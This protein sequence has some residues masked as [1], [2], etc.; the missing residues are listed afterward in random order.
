MTDDPSARRS[1]DGQRDQVNRRSVLKGATALAA[2]AVPARARITAAQEPAA[3]PPAWP[4]V[5]PASSYPAPDYTYPD[6]VIGVSYEDSTPDFPQPPGAPKGAPNILLVLLDDV[7]FAWLEAFGGVIASPTVDRLAADGLR[8]TAFHTTALCSPTRA[9]LLTGRNHHSVGTGVIEEIASGYPGYSGL[10]PRSAATIGELLHY[11][12]YATGWWGKNHNIPDNQLS[13]SGPFDRWPTSLGF[14]YFYGFIGGECDQFYPPLYR[15]TTPVEAPATPE[16]GYQLTNDLTDDCIRWIKAQTAIAP[17]K[18]FFAYFSPGA[19]HAP[20]QPPLDWRG[21]HAGMFDMGWDAYREQAFERQLELG[22]I[23][24]DSQ[25]TERPGQIPAWEDATDDEK[26][27]Y[28]RLVENFADFLGHADYSVGRLVDTLETLGVRDNTL[29]FYILGDNGSSAEG[30]PNGTIND[31]MTLTGINPPADVSMPFIDQIGLPGTSP[32]YPYGWA[33]AGDAPYKWTKQVA[34][35]FGGT[36]NP[37]IVSWPARID[38][39]GGTRWQFHH[40]IDIVPTIL[41]VVGIAQP[42]TVNG[43]AQKPIEGTSI[44]Y[45][46]DAAN[47]DAPTRHTTQYFEIMGNRAIYSDG[48]VAAC[49]HGRTPWESGTN[50]DFEDDVWELYDLSSDWTEAN[51]L[52]ASNPKKLRELQDLFMIEAARYNVFPLDDRGVQRAADAGLRP[53]YFTGRDQI[54]LYGGMTRLPEGSAPKLNNVHHAIT[55]SAEI[56]DGGA[57]GVL[58]ALGGDSAGFSLFVKDQKLVYEY[59]WFNVARYRVTSTEPVPSGQVTLGFEFTPK[60]DDPGSPADVALTINGAPAGSGSVDRQVT[61]R[62]GTE[63]LDIGQDCMSPVSEEYGAARFFPFTGDI[64]TVE[65]D[66]PKGQAILSP[67]ERYRLAIAMA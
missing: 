41:E 32:H 49:F 42:T 11:N 54:T 7:G 37:M 4:V 40:I 16:D 56:P 50:P 21:K 36:R 14:D 59:N 23:P 17:D 39:A 13:S 1:Q 27:L 67:E 35:H 10:I 48:W 43:I 28:A 57:E 2:A 53:G 3:E 9:A 45:T 29:I 51:D 52:A 31:M 65:I 15:G 8:Y 44:A 66:F 55:V 12:G 60:A 20:H 6:A 61:A 34:S 62:F 25:L 26:K 33:W 30:G 63:S 64:A 46:F 22:V 58:V 18:P 5:Q 24:P 38:D 47:A 19:A